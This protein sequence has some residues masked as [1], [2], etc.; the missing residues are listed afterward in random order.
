MTALSKK[1]LS[2]L[3]AKLHPHNHIL[4]FFK[5]IFYIEKVN[6]IFHCRNKM[7]SELRP[8]KRATLDSGLG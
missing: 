1:T 7:G 8:S 6:D 3:N 4:R 2:F 5:I